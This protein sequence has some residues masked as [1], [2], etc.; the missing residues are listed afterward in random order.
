MLRI[1]LNCSPSL[2]TRD[3]ITDLNERIEILEETIDDLNLDHHASKVAIR[4]LTTVINSM[5]GEPGLLEDPIS[6]P[7]VPPLVTFNHPAQKD[8]EENLQRILALLLTVEQI[9]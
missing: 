6:K 1:L 4:V 2:H 9:A 8:Y 7:K 3:K 5:S